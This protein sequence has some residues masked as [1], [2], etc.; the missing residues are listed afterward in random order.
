MKTKRFLN[1]P[2][3]A[4]LMI[5]LSLGACTATTPDTA[6]A[7]FHTDASLET[8]GGTLNSQR[9]AEYAP[10]G[11][12]V[13]TRTSEGTADPVS[14]QTESG[15]T[16]Q[17][18]GEGTAGAANIVIPGI[19]EGDLPT[20]FQVLGQNDT[21]IQ[22]GKI[23]LPNGAIAEVELLEIDASA[24]R[25]AR[26]ET[27]RVYVDMQAVLNEARAAI[28]A[29]DVEKFDALM[30]SLDSMIDNAIKLAVPVP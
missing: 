24:T 5:G 15:G 9:V 2:I 17:M 21:K 14:V 7:T 1:F 30:N 12:L 4:L 11:S 13:F 3:A 28:V 29:G 8:T 23:T 27:A 16:V 10:D 19:N 26:A 20:V 6:G 25:L 22:G 18:L